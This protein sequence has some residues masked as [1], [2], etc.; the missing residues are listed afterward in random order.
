MPRK[1]KVTSVQGALAAFDAAREIPEPPQRLGKKEM[2][3]W[4]AIYS[5]RARDEWNPLDLIKAVQ[6]ARLYVRR[7][8]EQNRLH[9]EGG[10]VIKSGKDGISKRN[11]RDIHLIQ[12]ENLIMRTEKHLRLH[13]NADHK[14]P[15][16][17]RSARIAE[18]AAR[19][20]LKVTEQDDFLPTFDDF[21]ADQSRKQ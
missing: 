8:I 2:V 17:I 1:I 19:S 21:S 4:I 9:R 5:R 16:Q 11:P 3:Y 14:D 13:S 10:S 20:A 7:D 6:L 12:A 15:S 18:E